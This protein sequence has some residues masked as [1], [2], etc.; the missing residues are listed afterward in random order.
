MK[1]F[2]HRDILDRNLTE[3]SA[4]LRITAMEIKYNGVPLGSV[5]LPF[6]QFRKLAYLL[7]LRY[8]SLDEGAV[9]DCWGKEDP[10]KLRLIIT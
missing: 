4:S 5:L 1:V 8:V 6:R 2:F 7:K 3:S 9:I 10:E